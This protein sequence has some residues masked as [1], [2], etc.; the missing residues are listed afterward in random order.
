MM[1]LACFHFD[2]SSCIFCF[3]CDLISFSV[4]GE[5]GFL[6][7]NNICKLTD[8][9]KF[10]RVKIVDILRLQPVPD[11][12]VAATDCPLRHYLPFIDFCLLIF[13]FFKLIHLTI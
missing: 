6:F 2:Q 4:A 3:V 9:F 10:N 7:F 5:I 13:H 12:L 1:H 11:I 8:S